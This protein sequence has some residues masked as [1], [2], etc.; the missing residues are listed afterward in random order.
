MRNKQVLAIV[1]L[2]CATLVPGMRAQVSVTASSPTAS[3]PTSRQIPFEFEV[4]RL[5]LGSTQTITVQVWDSPAGGNLVFSE[6]HPGVKVGLLG[7]IEFLIGALTPGGIP[8]DAFPSGTS[9][10]LDVIDVTRR[11][12][13]LAGRKPLYAMPFALSAGAQ[14]PAGPAGPQGPQGSSGVNGMT[15]PQGPAG[16]VG[17][18]GPTGAQGLPGPPGSVGPIGP[19]GLLGPAGPKGDQGIMGLQGPQGPSGVSGLA[20]FSCPTGQNVTGFDATA[21]PVCTAGT[22]GGGDTGPPDADHDGIPDSIDPCPLVPNVSYNGGS[23][24][25]ASIYDVNKGIAAPGATIELVSVLV[26]SVTGSQITVIVKSTDPTFQ[27]PD[28]SSLNI[29]LGALTAPPLGSRITAVGVVIAG[30]SFAPAA[31]LQVTGSGETP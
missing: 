17:P 8:A 5:P 25:P 13:C 31:I 24:C 7:E 2:L 19:Q 1:G 12:V 30:P 16:P 29:N 14:G 3:V 21:K 27:G 26:T 9:R 4:T 20:N 18:I 10:Y 15:G 23:Y 28:F 22:T 6:V 11:S